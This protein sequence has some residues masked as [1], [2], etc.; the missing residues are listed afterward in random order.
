MLS[1]PSQK[2][3]ER[4]HQKAIENGLSNLSQ[5]GRPRHSRTEENIEAIKEAFCRSTKKSI[6]RA[7]VGVNLSRSTIHRI[8][9]GEKLHPYVLCLLHEIP[10]EDSADR[11][12]F[13]STIS[14]SDCL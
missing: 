12:D 7:P 3:I 8:L 13:A 4:I 5:V 1:L 14:R 11:L 10:E 9:Q 6:R 2:T